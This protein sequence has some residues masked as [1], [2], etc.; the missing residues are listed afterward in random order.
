MPILRSFL[1][2]LAA[3][4]SLGARGQDAPGELIDVPGA[5]AAVILAH[6]KAQGPDGQV[7]GP[8]RRSIAK[9][10]GF[11][12]LSVQ[13]PV[14]SNPDYRAYAATFPDAYKTIQT[15]MTYLTGEKGF[16]RVYVLGYSMGARMTAAFLAASDV[17]A[18]VGY[19]GVGL[20]EGGGEPLDAN[21]SI[22]KLHV[23][24]LDLYADQT[25]LDV[26][27]A[28]NR[29]SLVGDRYK[30]ICIAGANHSFK[31]HEDE[32]SAEIVAWLKAQEPRR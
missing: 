13:L 3:T 5:S 16:E 23:P 1:L 28:G 12:T 31:G 18:V 26:T 9:E 21:S 32:L 17:P 11:T 25:L 27:S 24:I 2:V 14:L 22:R 10:G 4:L 19:V 29:R 30:Q 20:L 6:G 8:L 15:A 7:V